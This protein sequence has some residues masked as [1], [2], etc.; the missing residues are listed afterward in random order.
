MEE[1]FIGGTLIAL[2]MDGL[3]PTTNMKMENYYSDTGF[4]TFDINRS[5][6]VYLSLNGVAM[7][8]WAQKEGFSDVSNAT[9]NVAQ[10]NDTTLVQ[11]DRTYKK[12][13]EVS[14]WSETPVTVSLGA[15]NQHK[16]WWIIVVFDD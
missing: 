4:I 14:E 12:Y 13:Y 10:T 2:P 6:T 1:K 7:P 15:I 8:A 9:E 5:A 11:M 3:I 16:Y